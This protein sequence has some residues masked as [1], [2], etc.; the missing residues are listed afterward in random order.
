VALLVWHN[1][2]SVP[3]KTPSRRPLVYKLR[4]ATAPPLRPSAIGG[5]G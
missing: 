2:S 4:P 5:A 3:V 1:M